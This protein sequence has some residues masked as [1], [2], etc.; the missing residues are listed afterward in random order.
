M[1]LR[2][3][4]RAVFEWRYNPCILRAIRYLYCELVRIQKVSAEGNSP[5]D[6]G[7]YISQW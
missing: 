4:E 1:R 5:I 7:G 3:R 2:Q 6:T